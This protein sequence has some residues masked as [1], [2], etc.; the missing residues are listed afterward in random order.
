[1]I[2]HRNIFHFDA[3][4]FPFLIEVWNGCSKWWQSDWRAHSQG[5]WERLGKQSSCFSCKLLLEFFIVFTFFLSAVPLIRL[6]CF[7]TFHF[8]SS[9]VL[10]LFSTASLLL[11]D[12]K[13]PPSIELQLYWGMTLD[14]GYLSPYFIT[15][16]KTKECVSILRYQ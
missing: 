7:R 6:L 13:T 2:I 12:R 16:H 10:C 5:F 1:M 8:V 9:T 4:F 11:Q 15:N 14:R 3:F